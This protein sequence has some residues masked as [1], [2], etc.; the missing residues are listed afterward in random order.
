[1]VSQLFRAG[2]KL[3][4]S[5]QTMWSTINKP[6][7]DI[8]SEVGL[9][10]SSVPIF[11]NVTLLWLVIGSFGAFIIYTLIKWALDIIS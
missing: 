5:I 8:A 3:L 6:L 2:E 1:M 4:T 9:D 11:E 10:L 7:A